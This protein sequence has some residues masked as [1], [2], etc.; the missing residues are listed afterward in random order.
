[1]NENLLLILTLKHVAAIAHCRGLAGLSDNDAIRV[2]RELT[3][4][5]FASH[6]TNSEMAKDV[7][8]ALDAAKMEWGRRK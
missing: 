1:M 7:G 4:P 2:I 8:R 3:L 6:R 5:Y